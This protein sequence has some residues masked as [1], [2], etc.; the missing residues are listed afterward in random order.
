MPEITH[1]PDETLD[2]LVVEASPERTPGLHLSQIIRSILQSLEPGK[3]GSGPIDP[4]YTEPGFAFERVLETAFQSRR[5]DIFRPGEVE[6][7]GVICSPDGVELVGGEVWLEEFKSTDMSMVGCPLDPKFRKW[8][9]QIA[10]YCYVLQTTKSRL[11]VLWWRGDYKKVRRAYT[12]HE[13]V[14]TW[15]E[16]ESTWKFLIDHARMK[17]WLVQTPDG[18]MD[19]SRIPSFKRAS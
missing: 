7:D 5:V 2:R 1:L 12:V 4:L 19:A 13:I 16:L 10:A 11:R 17:G 8:L 15:E 3:Y 6:K 14:W 18:L 9:W